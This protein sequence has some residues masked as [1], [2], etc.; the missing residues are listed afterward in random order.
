MSLPIWQA[1]IV[2][3]FGDIIPSATITVKDE[4]TGLGLT[5]Y[6]DRNGTSVLG[7][8]G[9][10]TAGADGFAQFFAPAGNYSINAKQPSNGFEKTFDFVVLSGTAATRATGTGA[11][12]VPLNSDLPVF[13]GT[14]PSDIPTNNDLGPLITGGAYMTV[15]GTA[16]AITLTSPA[17]Y[18]LTSLVTGM[19]FRFKATTQNTGAITI[20]V[21][22][23][24]AVAG[25]TV[26]G[27]ACPAD[28]IRNDIETIITYDGTDFFVYREVQR[29]SNVNGDYDK[30]ANGLLIQSGELVITC[31][32]PEGNI[33]GT[34]AGTV[35]LGEGSV[36]FPLVFSS[37][38]YAKSSSAAA[39]IALSISDRFLTTSG[40]D[41]RFY[42]IASGNTFNVKWL[43]KGS[44]Y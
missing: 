10:F 3:E 40:F 31:N 44:W 5:V 24:A 25:K 32:T 27:V 6:S 19:Q 36:I 28:Y 14:A 12:D 26:T 39:N 42:G 1:T 22:G 13:G 33:F 29:G 41:P 4:T 17:G 37:V 16:D 11:G 30:F 18:T 43:A 2:N 8:N 9:V 34:T 20:S 23:I 38:H 15:G 35:Y 7:T 21:D